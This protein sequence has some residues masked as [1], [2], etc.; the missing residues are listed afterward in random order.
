MDESR[1]DPGGNRGDC[2]EDTGGRPGDGSGD[3]PGECGKAVSAWYDR[4]GSS[5][6]Y[7]LLYVSRVGGRESQLVSL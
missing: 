4:V 6:P 7:G 1:E 2:G 5:V 3:E